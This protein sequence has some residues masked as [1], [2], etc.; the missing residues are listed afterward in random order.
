MSETLT[1]DGVTYGRSLATHIKTYKYRFNIEQI[2]QEE[3]WQLADSPDRYFLYVEG[4]NGLYPDENV[5]E[6]TPDTTKYI[7]PMTQHEAQAWM[8][9]HATRA[10]YQAQFG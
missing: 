5:L 4:T 9:L 10:E 7:V 6:S 8:Y 1:I 2:T 3:L